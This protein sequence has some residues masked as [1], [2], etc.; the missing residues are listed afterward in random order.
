MNADEFLDAPATAD[1]FLDAPDGGVVSGGH[2]QLDQPGGASGSWE[3]SYFARHNKQFQESYI[4]RG[5]KESG[6]AIMALDK[7]KPQTIGR[8]LSSVATNFRG[9]QIAEELSG[10]STPL[11]EDVAPVAAPLL[12][13]GAAVYRPLTLPVGAA[14]Q[15]ATGSDTAG[16]VAEVAAGIAGGK[17]APELFGMGKHDPVIQKAK[18][19]E[20][21]GFTADTPPPEPQPDTY[22]PPF[23]GPEQ[24]P[25]QQQLPINPPSKRG[26]GDVEINRGEPP[27]TE[28][29]SGI[30]EAPPKAQETADI[31]GALQRHQAGLE[32]PP[33][34]SDRRGLKLVKDEP[35]DIGF[36]LADIQRII[37]DAATVKS[38]RGLR[39]AK[40][41]PTI[42]RSELLPSQRGETWGDRPTLEEIEASNRSQEKA[43]AEF[44]AEQRGGP[45][46][47]DEPPPP[48]DPFGGTKEF[49]A[50]PG[51]TAKVIKAI[52]ESPMVEKMKTGLGTKWER[53]E[54]LRGE[55]KGGEAA[56]EELHY[57][58][59][60]D[61][62]RRQAIEFSKVLSDSM[63]AAEQETAFNA[64]EAIHSLDPQGNPVFGTKE[65][66]TLGGQVRYTPQQGQ[67]FW[68]NLSP[69][70]QNAVKWWVG[71]REIL[72]TQNKILGDIEG[73]IHHFKEVKKK[74]LIDRA[75]EFV[76]AKPQTPEMQSSGV[77]RGVKFRHVKSPQ[78]RM[79][80]GDPDIVKNFSKAIEKNLIDSSDKLEYNKFIDK[81]KDAMTDPM[82]ENGKYDHNKFTE[83]PT[84]ASTRGTQAVG[85]MGGG[86]II[87]KELYDDFVRHVEGAK[88]SQEVKGMARD[89][90]N[91][92]RMNLL[93]FEPGTVSTN[94]ISGGLQYSLKYID[95]FWHG[96]LK[97]DVEKTARNTTALFQ[98]FTKV[99]RKAV[100][101]EAF[102]ARSNIRTQYGPGQG[103][104]GQI[105]DF[106]MRPFG[107]VENYWKR[108]IA[109]SEMQKGTPLKADALIGNKAEL[110]RINKVIDQF[111]YNYNNI[112]KKLQQFRD[113][114]LGVG[115]VPFPVYFYK[116][117]RM[118]GRYMAAFNPVAKM[119]TADRLARM[120]TVATIGM[121][122]AP[123]TMR[124]GEETR[125][126]GRTAV[127]GDMGLRTVKYPLINVTNP[128]ALAREGISTGP[129]AE[130]GIRALGFTGEYDKRKST[131]A[132]AGEIVGSM[133]PGGRMTEY[134]RKLYT[135][136]THEQDKQPQTFGEA[137]LRKVPFTPSLGKSYGRRP[138][139]D[140]EAL[141]FLTGINL[142]RGHK[143]TPKRLN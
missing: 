114:P 34:P 133:V 66:G 11:T 12:N 6:E 60:R 101:A 99:A 2:S 80:T 132:I 113:S 119:E 95:D 100:P 97:G 44:E 104:M 127:G 103:T 61:L 62:G 70:S 117:S 121:A 122:V 96:I 3:P 21:A 89:L 118:Y 23:E 59:A 16:Q 31:Y 30:P 93:T 92:Y 108:V 72:R 120:L 29:P 128:T 39:I 94:A 110:L 109:L 102:G 45:K 56:A 135:A 5:L 67:Q 15:S 130:A 57:E 82:P 137:M 38:R 136:A 65:P 52:Q 88:E 107:A 81:F 48:D 33:K 53:Y 35:A 106:G 42:D 140:L 74:S 63:P 9:P 131:G 87:R 123:L 85:Q 69:A 17:F 124:S 76:G 111:A 126:K 112:P 27:T 55:K 78:E 7:I 64:A 18:S 138:E 71:E 79:R 19:K 41:K 68:N 22:R 49:Q 1:E 14:V 13:A 25:E 86:R 90:A 46:G 28:M 125:K 84:F 91:F 143:K 43:M 32:K 4:G 40:D 20:Y 8:A 54:A 141:K 73:Y 83:I 75:A 142:Q 58:Y 77:P 37:D 116:L 51:F 105:A 10:N 129:I 36:D 24:M 134:G 26:A 115:V 50:F 47:P 98:A 139:L